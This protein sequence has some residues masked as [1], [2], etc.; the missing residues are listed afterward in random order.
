MSVQHQCSRC[1]YDRRL[2]GSTLRLKPIYGLPART[3]ESEHHI[4][5]PFDP[6]Y[7][8]QCQSLWQKQRDNTAGWELINAGRSDDKQ[9]RAC[10]R[11]L[12]AQIFL[13][14]IGSDLDVTEQD[15]KSGIESSMDNTLQHCLHRSRCSDQDA[16]FFN[17]PFPLLKEVEAVSRRRTFLPNSVLFSQGQLVKQVFG[18][19]SG[20]VW[21]CPQK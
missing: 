10:A 1:S 19:C 9:E 18:I 11:T 2:A 12:L 8:L 4:S 7:L 16:V 6:E 15:H 20:T 3:L 13:A 21:T 17:L 14:T 5:L